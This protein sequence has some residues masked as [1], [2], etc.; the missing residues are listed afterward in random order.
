MEPRISLVTLGVTDLERSLRFYR[1]G[2]GWRPSS[3]SVEGD[4]AFFQVGPLVLALWSRAE[5]AKDAGLFDGGGW[6]AVALA[7]NVRSRDEADL[8][9]SR[10][11]DAGGRLLKAAAATEW[12]GYSGL[13]CRS[14][15][16]PLGDRVE[17]ALADRGRRLDPPPRLRRGGEGGIRTRDGLPHTAFPVRRPR[18]L[19]DLSGRHDTTRR[20]DTA[21]S[22][23]CEWRRG[24]DSN[25]RCF[26]TPLFE[27]GTINH[28]DTSPPDRIA[29]ASRA[30]SPEAP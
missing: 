2:L 24:R 6:G 27:S 1:D 13:H 21:G 3:A 16:P 8:A 17:P 5:L 10:A 20:G 15:R 9:V 14:G 19:G 30:P 4:V 7:H 22:W 28:S 23:T 25:P 11:L 26:R 18:P 29:K 12:G